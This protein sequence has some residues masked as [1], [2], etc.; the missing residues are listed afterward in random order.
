[1][2]SR[3][4]YPGR[5][6]QIIIVPREGDFITRPDPDYEFMH[7]SPWSYDVAIPLL[8]VGPAVKAGTYETPASQQDVAP[9]L[10]EALGVR[11]PAAI[12]GHVLPVLGG[13]KSKPLVVMLLVLDGMRRDYFDRYA[14]TMPTLTA[15]RSRGAWFTNAQ[16]SILPSNTAVGHATLSTGTDPS[17]HGITGVNM[18]DASRRERHDFFAGCSPQD[19]MAPTLSDILEH[20]TAGRAII[21]AQGSVDRA[22]TPLAG[23]GACS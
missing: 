18:Y 21:V 2:L 19:L 5:T 22:A 4:D 1:M 10:A 17:V 3:S 7:G 11:M 20:E 14:D 6:A 9:T 16:L 23:H 15:L 12:T 13:G 8:F